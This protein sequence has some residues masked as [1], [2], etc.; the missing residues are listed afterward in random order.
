[1]LLA[2]FESPE[3]ERFVKDRGG[4]LSVSTQTIMEG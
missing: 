4:V 2:L 1:M 3:L